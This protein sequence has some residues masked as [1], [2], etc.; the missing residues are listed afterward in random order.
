MKGYGVE[1]NGNEHLS[2]IRK[3][4]GGIHLKYRKLDNQKIDFF[5]G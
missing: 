4:E 2:R 5:Y 3:F 1:Y